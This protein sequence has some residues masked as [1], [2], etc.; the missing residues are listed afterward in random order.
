VVEHEEK[1]TFCMHNKGMNVLHC[2]GLLM[3][4]TIEKITTIRQGTIHCNIL[5][6]KSFKE[7]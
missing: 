3:V 1:K 7:E 5:V 2:R 6:K 4:V